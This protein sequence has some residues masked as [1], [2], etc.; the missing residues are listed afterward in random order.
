M[1]LGA[2]FTLR[3]FNA[4]PAALPTT[5][6]DILLSRAA[7]IQEQADAAASERDHMLLAW[8]FT[9]QTTALQVLLGRIG[10]Q[11]VSETASKVVNTAAR[12]GGWP[13]TL[14]GGQLILS[15]EHI[16]VEAYPLVLLDLINYASV[17]AGQRVVAQEMALVEA[18]MSPETVET[19][20]QAGMRLPR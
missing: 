11:R 10:G 16:P 1:F 17:V 4:S 14:L 3:P 8:Y 2:D 5:H 20:Y 7:Q 18:H 19:A 15:A 12:R 9:A 13:I 6:G